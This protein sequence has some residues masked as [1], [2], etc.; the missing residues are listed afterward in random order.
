VSR[1][2][3]RA[4]ELLETVLSAP[5]PMGLMEAAEA[6]GLD[7]STAQRMLTYLT[8]RGSLTRDPVTKRYAIGP[9]SFALAATVSA[10]N[11]LRVA[12]A[13]QLDELQAHTGETVSLHLRVGLRRV[14]VDGRESGHPLRRVVP[15]GESLPL[16]AG[17]SGKVV[18]A[19]LPEDQ[20]LAVFDAAGVAQED[21]D[22][23]RTD[24]ERARAQ[25]YLH[26]DSDRTLG[27][28][29]VSAPIFDASGVVG[30]VTVAGPSE[31]W[32]TASASQ[33]APR[34]SAAAAAISKN[35]G[36]SA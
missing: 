36:G 33:A 1:T 13:P 28:R 8:E 25:G 3:D 14:C 11:D 29:A 26:T 4:L 23:V 2:L 22:A 9:R 35:L 27:I 19:Q 21:R 24:L 17:P 31:R 12:A 16:C 18:L 10:R 34:I 7:K 15:L 6:T 30:S 32:G 20:I 5:E